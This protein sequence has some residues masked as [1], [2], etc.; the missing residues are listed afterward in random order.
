MKLYLLGIE[1]VVVREGV[2]IASYQI[3]DGRNQLV[4]MHTEKAEAQAML[5]RLQEQYPNKSFYLA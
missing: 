1:P 4:S 2:V 3:V 5:K